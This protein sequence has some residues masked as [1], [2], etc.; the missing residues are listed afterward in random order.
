MAATLDRRSELGFTLVELMITVLILGILI[1][2][3][4]PVFMGARTR[5]QDAAAKEDLRTGLA[6]GLAFYAE[7]RDWTNFDDVQGRAEEPNIA[8]IDGGAPVVGQTSI[9]IHDDQELLL[10]RLSQSGIYFCVAQVATSPATARGSGPDFD[11]VNSMAD[12]TGGW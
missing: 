5:A 12:C 7:T 8:W 9:H 6:A 10:V 1:A 11:D 2:I 4:L 3:G